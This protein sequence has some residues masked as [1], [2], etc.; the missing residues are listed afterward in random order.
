MVRDVEGDALQRGLLTTALE[1]AANGIL[2]TDA[3]G[4][5]LWSNPAFTAM[6]GYS[7]GEA[8]G[9]NPRFLKSGRHDSEFYAE[10]WRTI[11]AGQTW[12]GEMVNRRKNGSL[13]HEQQ[14]IAPVRDAAG[15]I[16]HFIAIKQDV[17]ERV[18]A[19]QALLEHERLLQTV[20]S[21]LPVGVWIMDADGKLRQS[22]P[23]AWQIWSG[24]R[25]AGPTDLREC[26]GWWV[27]TGQ[28]IAPDEWAMTRVLRGGEPVLG[29]EIEIECLDGTRKIIL[30][31]AVPIPGA[32][33]T[34]TGAIVVNQDITA[35][36]QAREGLRR[37]S[38][39]LV[40]VQESERRYVARE[41]HDDVG[42]AVTS[43]L[44]GFH[45]L[46]RAGEQPASVVAEIAKLKEMA[47]SL[48]GNLDDISTELLPASLDHVGLVETLHQYAETISN[49]HGLQVQVEATDLACLDHG[50]EGRR[51]PHDME[52]ALFRIVQEA[53]ENVLRA[54]SATAVDVLLTG[55]EN[56]VALIIEDNGQPTDL[57]SRD[58]RRHNHF[59][60]VGMQERARMLGGTLTMERLVDG[61]TTIVVEVPYAGAYSAGR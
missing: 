1:A 3:R 34:I 53:L 54:G 47:R 9:R 55:R 5:I 29:E 23:A 43:L 2:I 49:K 45:L 31:S 61:G 37:L 27:K 50:R 28:P 21:A 42:Q 24:E 13:Y 52:V 40:E 22:N 56:H 15:E 11:R 39:R 19:Q 51:L 48:V 44:L 32:D 6:T 38:R 35:E 60:M 41:L 26:K 59:E 10:L 7:A 57:A 36:Y 18:V 4:E 20:F 33:D 25:Y 46:E 58:T 16:T 30:N 17:T 12:H 8:L 14:T